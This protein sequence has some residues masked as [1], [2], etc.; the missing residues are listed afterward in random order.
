MRRHE[1]VSDGGFWVEGRGGVSD[2]GFWGEG[3]WG[4]ASR[5]ILG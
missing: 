5:E 4:S 3:T 2:G 1:G